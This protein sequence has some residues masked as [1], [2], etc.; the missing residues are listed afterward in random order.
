MTMSKV[1]PPLTF[2]D[3]SSETH[4]V[5]YIV[6]QFCIISPDTKIKSA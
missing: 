3:Q 4:E 1:V 6:A 5:P 2:H